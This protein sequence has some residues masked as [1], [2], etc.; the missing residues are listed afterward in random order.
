MQ[1]R[2]IPEDI[3]EYYNLRSK[4]T[5]DNCIYIRIKKGMYGLKQVAVLAYNQLKNKLQPQG[6]APVTGTVGLWEHATRQ[7]K[8]YFC[9]DDFGIKYFYKGDVN[10]LLQTIGKD[11]KCRLGRK[12]LLRT[13]F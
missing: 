13:H 5:S 4:V 7:A 10:H 11:Y 12:K 8:F 6:Y 2:Q 9:D 3:R 1:Y